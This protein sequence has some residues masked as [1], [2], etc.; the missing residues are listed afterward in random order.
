MVLSASVHMRATGIWPTIK[1]I[2]SW[3][4]VHGVTIPSS[5]ASMDTASRNNGNATMIMT[6]VMAVMSWKVSVVSWTPLSLCQVFSTE[7]CCV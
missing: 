7:S 2:A 4:M 5:H 1:S 3:T 6:V